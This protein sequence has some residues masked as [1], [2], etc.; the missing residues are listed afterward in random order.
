MCLF[1]ISLNPYRG[2]GVVIITA[3]LEIVKEDPAVQIS[4]LKS[5]ICLAIITSCRQIFH[6]HGFH[7]TTTTENDSLV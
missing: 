3:I 5:N 6:D 4:H 7:Y 2:C 1:P